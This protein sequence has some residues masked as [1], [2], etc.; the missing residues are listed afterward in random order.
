MLLDSK[1]DED[2]MQLYQK[3]SD[4]AFSI[5]YARHS[6]K[7]YG[8]LKAKVK[9]EE[10]VK[11]IFQEVFVKVHKSKN[12]YNSSYPF[13]AWL[14]TITKN[15]IVDEVRKNAKTKNHI[16]ID[17]SIANQEPQIEPN[18]KEV[19]PYLESLPANQKQALELRYVEEKTFDE[20]SEVLQTSTVNVRK[21]ISRGLQKIRE[22]IKEGVKP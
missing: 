10:R 17:D 16:E 20:I 5:L 15:S 13:L 2:L 12:L 6:P 9:S 18:L 14:F 7:I 3:G 8:Y 4:Q 19:M 22:R 21:V 1:T 11:D